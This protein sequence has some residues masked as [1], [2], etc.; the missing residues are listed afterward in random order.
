[1]K[2]VAYGELL[3]QLARYPR[4]FPVGFY[5]AGEEDGF[6]LIDTGLSGSGQV[7]RI[8]LTHADHTGSLDA[9]GEALPEAE[10][11][12]TACKDRFLGGELVLDLGEPGELRGSWGTTKTRLTRG[13]A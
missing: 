5:L 2:A 7:R 11:L 12:I 13:V 4:I 6:T 9:L 1:M 8:G 3:V 10:V